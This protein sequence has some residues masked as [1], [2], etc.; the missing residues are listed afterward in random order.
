MEC[1]AVPYFLFRFL[2][3][4]EFIVVFESQQREY[5]KFLLRAALLSEFEPRSSLV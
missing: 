3:P 5:V 4:E 2:Q 1:H